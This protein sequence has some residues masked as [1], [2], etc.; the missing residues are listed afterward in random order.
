MKLPSFRLFMAATAGVMLLLSLAQAQTKAGD[1]VWQR[2]YEA[3]RSSF[4]QAD[5]AAA[6]RQYQVALQRAQKTNSL[7]AIAETCAALAQL[8]DEQ[9][10]FEPAARQYRCLLETREKL[11]GK[12]NYLLVE[13]IYQVEDF[14]S[15]YNKYPEAIQLALRQLQLTE[16]HFAPDHSSVIG[17]LQIIA[18]LY[19]LAGNQAEAERYAKLAE[20]REAGAKK[21]NSS[22]LDGDDLLREDE[23]GRHGMEAYA[24][25]R[26]AEA[27]QH[28]QNALRA[29]E[30]AG[31]RDHLLAVILEAIAGNYNAQQKQAAGT[32][33]Y[34]RA[35]ALREE[36]LPWGN[37]E[38]LPRLRMLSTRIHNLISA[39]EAAE[40]E[41]PIKRERWIKGGVK[42]SPQTEALLKKLVAL[43]ERAVGVEHMEYAGALSSLKHYY[44]DRFSESY[45]ELSERLRA[46]WQRTGRP[47]ATSGKNPKNSFGELHEMIA[48][49]AGDEVRRNPYLV[50]GLELWRRVLAIREKLFAPNHHFARGELEEMT[51]FFQ[52]YGLAAEQAATEQR[53]AAIDAAPKRPATGE[54]DHLKKAAAERRQLGRE[55]EAAEIEARVKVLEAAASSQPAQIVVPG[56]KRAPASALCREMNIFAL[57]GPTFTLPLWD[58]PEFRAAGDRMLVG[59]RS[60]WGDRPLLEGKFAEINP[61]TGKLTVMTVAERGS[62]WAEAKP[63][64]RAPHQHNRRYEFVRAANGQTEMRETEAYPRGIALEPGGT[65]RAEFTIQ[66][67]FTERKGL[68][69]DAPTKHLKLSLLRLEI[70]DGAKKLGEQTFKNTRD[71]WATA[72]FAMPEDVRGLRAVSWLKIGA[73]RILLFDNL[74]QIDSLYSGE[75]VMCALPRR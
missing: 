6:E 42:E 17:A 39:Y 5:Y 3:G 37:P 18:L 68:F 30:A 29:A 62:L 22:L 36:L 60:R 74:A 59:L 13:T 52:S 57:L 28:Y 8:Y 70:F 55:Q 11:L 54:F 24:Q 47:P 12:N 65:A 2:L 14:Y 32:P 23:N 27:G 75:F 69:D 10:K 41:D 44:L 72:F 9:E 66:T 25:G 20:A 7:P 40:R 48:Q 58:Q 35:V 67:E 71:D 16:K 46:E 45:R 1:A 21:K 50:K 38:L 4:D 19:A 26:V 63:L 33:F 34:A 43:W 61:D 56:E 53:I 51:R 15:R 49:V 73:R 64:V 31:Q